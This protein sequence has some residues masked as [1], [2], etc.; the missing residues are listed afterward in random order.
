MLRLKYLLLIDL[1][2]WLAM[3]GSMELSS[4]IISGCLVVLMPPLINKDLASDHPISRVKTF[5][6]HLVRYR[7]KHGPDRNISIKLESGRQHLNPTPSSGSDR[8]LTGLRG[9]SAGKAKE[10]DPVFTD[11]VGL[12]DREDSYAS[13]GG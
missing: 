1:Q 2:S 6:R 10:G 7:R 11:H 5:L 4:G 12:L 9:P 13:A 8:E 3:W